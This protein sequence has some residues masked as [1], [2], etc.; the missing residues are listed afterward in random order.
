MN[1]EQAA[2]PAQEGFLERIRKRFS[3][4]SSSENS[5]DREPSQRS[6]MSGDRTT[7]P[8]VDAL[9]AQLAELTASCDR[10]NRRMEEVE[11]DISSKKEEA[12]QKLLQ[13]IQRA[14][15][16]SKKELAE[17]LKSLRAEESTLAT[18]INDAKAALAIAQRTLQLHMN[19]ENLFKSVKIGTKKRAVAKRAK[20]FTSPFPIPAAILDSGVPSSPRPTKSTKPKSTKPKSAKNDKI[21]VGHFIA[22]ICKK[23]GKFGDADRAEVRNKAGLQGND[24]AK[25]LDADSLKTAIFQLSR[26]SVIPD[27]VPEHFMIENLTVTGL[28]KALNVAYIC[29]SNAPVF[30]QATEATEAMV[31]TGGRRRYAPKTRSIRTNARSQS[32]RRR[33]ARR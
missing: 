22:A 28:Q 7:A 29:A 24:N 23:R 2:A 3:G 19:P 5:S 14:R 12:K 1:P 17:D 4:L 33:T 8:D 20:P 27:C 11:S 21:T 13:I 26:E 10:L 25:E 18:E 31:T 32:P 16:E 6:D 9:H 15:E 30:P